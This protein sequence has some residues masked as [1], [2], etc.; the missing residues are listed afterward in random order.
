[1]IQALFRRRRNQHVLGSLLRQRLYLAIC[2]FGEDFNAVVFDLVP[3]EIEHLQIGMLQHAFEDCLCG[4]AAE[5]VPAEIELP[6]VV[7]SSS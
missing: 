3:A 4:F 1:M 5:L 2:T 7:V 6:H